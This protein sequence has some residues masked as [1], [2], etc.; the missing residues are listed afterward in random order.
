MTGER[1]CLPSRRAA[2]IQ[3]KGFSSPRPPSWGAD[4][5]IARNSRASALDRSLTGNPARDPGV[6]GA[7]RE[8][9]ACGQAPASSPP[10]TSFPRAECPFSV[11]FSGGKLRCWPAGAGPV[12]RSDFPVNEPARLRLG[13]PSLSPAALVFPLTLGESG[14]AYAGT[15][16]HDRPTAATRCAEAR[17][18]MQPVVPLQSGWSG[19]CLQGCG[20]GSQRRYAPANSGQVSKS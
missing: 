12:G 15:C 19:H 2:M 17:S 8:L 5:K 11:T 14:Q 20:A 9:V 7:D 16:G 13:P 6:L 18:T 10:K 4:R 1:G 3:R